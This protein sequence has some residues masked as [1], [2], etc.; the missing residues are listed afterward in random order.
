MKAE[1]N[2]YRVIAA[3]ILVPEELS[4][5]TALDVAMD[6]LD[7]ARS[8]SEAEKHGARILLD[9]DMKDGFV[10]VPVDDPPP[11]SLNDSRITRPG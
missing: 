1:I 5:D 10:S 8:R 3:L 2:R 7:A 6:L 4:E 11:W 9:E